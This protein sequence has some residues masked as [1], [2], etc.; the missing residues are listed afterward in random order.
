MYN[1]EFPIDSRFPESV[2]TEFACVKYELEATV[3]RS[4]VFRPNLLGTKEIPIIRTPAEG[5]LK[6]VEPIA[7]SRTWEDQLRYDIVISGKSFP[8]GSQVPIAF[9]LT[10]RAK[11]ACHRIKVY[12]TEIS[13]YWAVNKTVHRLD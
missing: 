5:S 9:K 10:P 3:E 1:V 4:G 11:V 8:L 2:V 6:H 7:I 13:R 12:V